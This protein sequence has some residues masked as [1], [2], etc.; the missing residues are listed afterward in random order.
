MRFVDRFEVYTIEASMVSER[1]AAL[2]QMYEK[3][4]AD[5]DVSP[6]MPVM[7][8]GCLHYSVTFSMCEGR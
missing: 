3:E 4:Y 2:S 1:V 6:A 8:H 7:M 5:V